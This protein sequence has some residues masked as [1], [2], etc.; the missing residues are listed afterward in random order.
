[1]LQKPNIKYPFFAY[2]IF[3]PG[4]IAYSRIEKY[5]KY[6]S[7]EDI[8][9]RLFLR[10]GI[11]FIS[12]DSDETFNTSGFLIEFRE[13]FLYDAY[14]VICEVESEKLY[15][16]KEILV[17]GK[18]ANV[19]I[20]R[21]PSRSRPIPIGKN[22]DGSADPYF[23]EAIEVIS[24]EIKEYKKIMKESY[25]EFDEIKCFFKL[26]RNYIL[27][28][29]AIE[30]YTGLKYGNGSKSS[31][32]EKFSEECIFQESLKKHIGE[33]ERRKIYRTDTL[34]KIELDSSSPKDSIDYY[35]TI[36]CNIVHRGKT[37]F[38]K[39]GIVLKSLEELLAIFQDVL[40]DTFK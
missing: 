13:D 15:Y 16:W 39:G 23:N 20:G 24:D 8:K 14:D 6:V 22:F 4:Q 29:A 18:P 28:W 21:K 30:R 36:R 40:D 32:N 17:C 7:Q 33:K 35:Y 1:M 19:L 34:D 5:V 10:D 3:K 25:K 31:N 27:L 12:R 37:P 26:Q 9:H 38:N 2:G 11:P